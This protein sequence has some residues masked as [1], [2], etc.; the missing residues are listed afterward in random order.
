MQQ[1]HGKKGCIYK[2][3]FF[4][5]CKE[6]Y[7]CM[8]SLHHLYGIKFDIL[9]FCWNLHQILGVWLTALSC[10]SVRMVQCSSHWMDF[11]EI[12]HW[13]WFWKYVK[14]IQVWLKCDKNNGYFMW[15]PTYIYHNIPLNSSKNEKCF[16]Q[17][18]QRKSKHTFYVL[19]FL[20]VFVSPPPKIVPCTR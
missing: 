1:W 14:N 19:I 18:L 12:W 11:Q 20:L 17:K 8:F 10:L 13:S 4:A 3:L 2:L 6:P 5:P 16:R 9:I 7:L 15:S